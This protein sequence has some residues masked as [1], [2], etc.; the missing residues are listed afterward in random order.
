LNILFINHEQP[1]L[2]S[3]H[4]YSGL[5]QLSDV[6]VI[7]YPKKVW[8]HLNNQPTEGVLA[9]CSVVC[10]GCTCPDYSLSDVAHMNF[11]VVIRGECGL[12]DVDSNFWRIR[13]EL[14][15]PP[16]IVTLDGWDRATVNQDALRTSDLYFKREYRLGVDYPPNVYPLPSACPIDKFPS[17]PETEKK[18]DVSFMTVLCTGARQILHKRLSKMEIRYFGVHSPTGQH[19]AFGRRALPWRDYLQKIKESKISVSLTAGFKHDP[20]WPASDSMK[21]WEIPAFGDTLLLSQTNWVKI[22]NDFE[23]KKEAVFLKPDL[24]NLEE[25]VTYYLNNED[26]RLNIAEAAYQK[27]LNHHIT[28]KRAAYMMKIIHEKMKN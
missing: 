19:H 15:P 4:I 25:L 9:S 22:P 26:E 16:F 13:E 7:E 18:Y 20:F 2:L 17:L 10:P 6:K 3:D 1:D 5:I 12:L 11:D 28:V 8:H 24:S 27:L 23:D 21:Y 14:S